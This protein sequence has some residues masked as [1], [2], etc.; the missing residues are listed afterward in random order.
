MNDKERQARV[1][2]L[3]LERPAEQRTGNGVR[4]FYRYL[5]KNRPELLKHGHPDPYHQLKTDLRGLILEL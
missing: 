2:D 1:R 5:E 3:W 4:A